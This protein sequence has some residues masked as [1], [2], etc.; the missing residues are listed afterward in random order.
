MLTVALGSLFNSLIL[1]VTGG[2]IYA[3]FSGLAFAALSQRRGTAAGEGPE[4]PDVGPAPAVEMALGA[5]DHELRRA[6]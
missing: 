2:L 6:A 4:A 3:Y 5:G 1:S